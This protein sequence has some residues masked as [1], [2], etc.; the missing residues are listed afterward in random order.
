VRGPY[1]QD[2]VGRLYQVSYSAEA[3]T[4]A[5]S[6]FYLSKTYELT[7]VSLECLETS[8]NIF[9]N[10]TLTV[11]S[12]LHSILLVFLPKT[13]HMFCQKT[14]QD[15]LKTGQNQLITGYQVDRAQPVQ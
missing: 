6:I 12:S 14:G 10:F 9:Y 3:C 13:T 15:C 11:V 7:I 4:T 5:L 8:E 2:P 1:I